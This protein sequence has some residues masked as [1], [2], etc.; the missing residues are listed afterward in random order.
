MISGTGIHRLYIGIYVWQQ[1]LTTRTTS[2][3]YVPFCVGFQVVFGEVDE[4][5]ELLGQMDALGTR[6]GKPAER[7][8]ITD[9][10]EL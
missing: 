6:G 9:C 7:V 2:C 4:G 10:G 3:I 5:F 8:T 1:L